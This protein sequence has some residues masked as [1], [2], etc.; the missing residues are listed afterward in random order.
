[1]LPSFRKSR[2]LCGVYHKHVSVFVTRV[3]W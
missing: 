3:H 2:W 1:V